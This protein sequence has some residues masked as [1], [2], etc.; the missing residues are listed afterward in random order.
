MSDAIDL[1]YW[2][3]DD[4]FPH[5]IVSHGDVRRGMMSPKVHTPLKLC[6]NIRRVFW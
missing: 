2:F 3:T 6:S 5:S 4:N 1:A